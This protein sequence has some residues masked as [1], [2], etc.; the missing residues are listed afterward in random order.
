MGEQRLTR[1]E[2]LGVGIAAVGAAGL[3]GCRAAAREQKESKP[4]NVRF[5]LNLLIY[6]AAFSKD[7]VDLIRKVADFGYDGVE[8]PFNDLSI[9]DAKATRAAREKAGVGLT[10]CC[11]LL[12]GM[13]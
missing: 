10:S 13:N 3:A 12:P 2:V 1:R 11:V 6:T 4:V 8:V 7:Q 9:L 5:G